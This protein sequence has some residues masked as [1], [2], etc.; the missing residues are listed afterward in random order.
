MCDRSVCTATGGRT[1]C[2]GASEAVAGPPTRGAG[3]RH[4]RKDDPHYGANGSLNSQTRLD[5]LDGIRGLAAFSVF[6]AHC[7]AMLALQDLGP[8]LGQLSEKIKWLAVPA[9]DVFFVLSG[10][11]LMY[12]LERKTLNAL[13]VSQFLAKRILRIYPTYLAAVLFALACRQLF[14]QPG[15]LTSTS[16]WFQGFWA[17]EFTLRDMRDHVLL[18]FSLDSSNLNPVLWTLNVE[19]R[20]SLLFP[21]IAWMLRPGAS[22]SSGLTLLALCI[23][24]LV[25]PIESLRYFPLFAMGAA[26]ARYRH[27]LIARLP[28]SL[29]PSL[30]LLLA[31]ALLLVVIRSTV[32]PGI[33]AQARFVHLAIGFF[34]AYAILLSASR[35]RLNAFLRSVPILFVG[36]ISYSFYLLHF[37]VL[38]TTSLLLAGYVPVPVIWGV[39]LVFSVA[40]ARASYQ[41]VE[42]PTQR[43]GHHL[44]GRLETLAV[45]HEAAY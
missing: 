24:I 15:P 28:I 36:K 33:M 8:V 22:A 29:T 23:G 18:I 20:M 44:A 32:Y 2:R 30:L 42:M 31:P 19:M 5:H 4:G 13:R 34:S 11:C 40:L 21:V 3:C 35:A 12:S 25:L 37:P 38:L 45:A 39:A 1:L 6:V 10:F 26:A 17:S 41:Y 16:A 9:V 43:L 7:M 27:A 14:Y